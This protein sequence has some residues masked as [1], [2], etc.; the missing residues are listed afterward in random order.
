MSSSKIS[1]LGLLLVLV[2]GCAT[3]PQPTPSGITL[4]TLPTSAPPTLAAT[5]SPAP[6]EIPAST[7][8]TVPTTTPSDIETENNDALDDLKVVRVVPSRNSKDVPTVGSSNP[9]RIRFNFPM[10]PLSEI[11]K[12]EVITHPLSIEP[13]LLYKGFWSN[14]YT[15]VISPYSE[16]EI[17]TTYK[18][19]LKPTQDL[20]GHE[21]DRYE[22]SFRTQLPAINYTDPPSHD[23]PILVG[24]TEPVAIH[25]NTV[26]D[27]GSVE[28]RLRVMRERDRWAALGDFKWEATGVTFTPRY[29]LDYDTLYVLELAPGAQDMK[30]KAAIGGTRVQFKTYP[31]FAM[32]SSQPADG[33]KNVENVIADGLR[34]TFTQPPDS[35]KLDVT[36][37]P[38]IERLSVNQYKNRHSPEYSN[39]SVG[40]AWK[41]ST[42]Y[43]VTVGSES[44][45]VFGER[46]GK[47]SLVH[48]KTAQLPPYMHINLPEL[49][50]YDSNGPQN[51]FATYTNVSRID[52]ELFRVPQEDLFKLLGYSPFQGSGGI[53]AYV[54]RYRSDVTE[55]TQTFDTPLNQT[56]VV[57]T[58]LGNTILTKTKP[59]VYI[60]RATAP[61]TENVDKTLLLVSPVNLALKFSDTEALVW[62]TN[63]ASGKPVSNQPLKIYNSI[64]AV[65]ATGISDTQ[66]LFRTPLQWEK[67]A[68]YGR[69]FAVT[70]DDAGNVTAATASDWTWGITAWDYGLDTESPKR[71]DEVMG[72]LYTDRPIYRTGQTVYFKGI[73]RVNTDPQ[74]EV[75]ALI[76][77]TSGKANASAARAQVNQ[78]ETTI[79]NSRGQEFSRQTLEVNE[80][81]TFNGKIELSE[82]AP[83]GDYNIQT[84][85]GNVYFTVDEYRKPEFQVN[86]TTDKPSYLN[87]DD[88]HVSVNSTYFFGGSV[89]NADVTWRVLTE[90]YY[91]HPGVDGWWDFGQDE[92]YY[93]DSNHNANQVSDGTGK[94]DS[95]GVFTITI[96][97]KLDEYSNSQTFTIEAE[98]VD[99]NHQVVANRTAMPIHRGEFYLGIRPNSYVG[100]VNKN[101]VVNLVAV[102]AY[103]KEGE[104]PLLAGQPVSVSVYSGKWYNVRELHNGVFEWR[105]NY[106]ETLVTTTNLVTDE[107]GHASAS[108]VPTHGGEYRIAVESSDTRDNVIKSETRLYVRGRGYTGWKIDNTNRIELIADKKSY[109]P[110]ET[111]QL[112]V[113]APF[114]DSQALVT[115]ERGGIQEVRQFHIAENTATIEIPIKGEYSTLR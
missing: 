50:L 3:P 13:P 112:V 82:N 65:V 36:V 75:P 10:V 46:L 31:H 73:L 76:K 107:Q 45:S 28:S 21:L 33:T 70:E 44:R 78:V 105:N 47:E 104:S 62:V 53:Q 18:V 58:T 63:L 17:A 61:E 56:S 16:F 2:I 87:G 110:G 23:R 79:Y 49:G 66:G 102:K 84:N 11:N 26:M 41:P 109:K 30:H 90:N 6:T 57:S 35:D 115:I 15:Y 14:A 113:L 9:I 60:L 55:W 72:N 39:V 64:G 99:A 37:I 59:G 92:Y 74:P 95:M 85:Y 108:F 22:W 114:A 101:E 106:S 100:A 40:G 43:T 51:I 24:V 98:I 71:G 68:Q 91:V 111:A 1:F 94:T 93:G 20:F 32:L 29:P 7:A 67:A 97:A 19:S 42:S 12:S 89:T 34:L 81:G 96:P 86:V 38:P 88:I 52:Y 5:P 8:T 77:H 48:F 103:A 27:R 25:F 54:P 69:L 83:I 4:A 80:F